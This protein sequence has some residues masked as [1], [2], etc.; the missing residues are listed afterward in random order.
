M[1]SFLLVLGFVLVCAMGATGCS[2]YE[3]G[4]ED[5]FGEEKEIALSELPDKVRE[6]AEGAVDGI[7]L[8]EA[9][10]EKED[11]KWI[12]E[13]EGVADGKEYEIEITPEGKI[14]EIEEEDDRQERRREARRGARER[15]GSHGR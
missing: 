9:E 14:L 11:G 7:V 3:N 6:A 2:L 4:V 15:R 1:K 5:D 8:K 12:Y 10:M 13:V